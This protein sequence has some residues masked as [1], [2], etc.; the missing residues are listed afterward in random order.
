MKKKLGM[1]LMVKKILRSIAGTRACATIRDHQGFPKIG[2]SAPE[3]SHYR[4]ATGRTQ[5][6]PDPTRH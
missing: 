2:R 4:A 3:P 6:H 1:H 5:R